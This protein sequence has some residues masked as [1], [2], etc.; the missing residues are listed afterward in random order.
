MRIAKILVG[1]VV[2][3][4]QLSA[5]RNVIGDNSL[6]VGQS[7]SIVNSPSVLISPPAQTGGVVM[8]DSVMH[9]APVYSSGA[10]EHGFSPYPPSGP[11]RGSDLLG[12]MQCDPHSCPNVWAGY[13]AQRQADL[14]RKCT[15]HGHCGGCGHGCG[16]GCG[17]CGGGACGAACGGCG[18]GV[19]KNRYRHGGVKSVGCSECSGAPDSCG[20]D[21]APIELSSVARPSQGNQIAT[22]A[23]SPSFALPMKSVR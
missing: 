12:F 13:E 7:D 22:S 17:S 2:I 18:V 20:C 3:V 5:V 11:S 21:T 15:P 14:R 19:V 23:S 16:H 10:V 6:V 9:H 8:H 1:C 4:L